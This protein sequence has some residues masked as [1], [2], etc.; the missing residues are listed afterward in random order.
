MKSYFCSTCRKCF[1]ATNYPGRDCPNYIS[2]VKGNIHV[3]HDDCIVCGKTWS[4]YQHHD[5]SR[6]CSSHRIETEEQTRVKQDTIDSLESQLTYQQTD[7]RNL[8]DTIIGLQ[9][10]LGNWTTQFPGQE[11]Q[12][13]N[14]TITGVQNYLGINDLNQLPAMPEAQ[15]LQTLIDFYNEGQGNTRRL[16]RAEGRLNETITKLNLNQVEELDNL[17]QLPPGETVNQLWEEVQN[18]RWRNREEQIRNQREHLRQLITNAKN[19]LNN[20]LHATLDDLLETQVEL[21]QGDNIFAQRLLD[22]FKKNL[23]ASQLAEEEINSLCQAQ[24]ELSRLEMQQRQ[25]NPQFEARQQQI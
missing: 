20:N 17:P 1:N 19:R 18:T 3:S 8:S 9:Q 7:N 16:R 15:N 12:Q 23:D 13:I 25:Q 5:W 6:I 4:I 22:K 11:P 24:T 21:S 14:T 10:K 2:W